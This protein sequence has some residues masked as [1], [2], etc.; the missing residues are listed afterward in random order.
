MTLHQVT[1]RSEGNKDTAEFSQKLSGLA[2]TISLCDHMGA[3][4]THWIWGAARSFRWHLSFPNYPILKSCSVLPLLGRMSFSEINGVLRGFAKQFRGFPMSN[5]HLFFEFSN[6]REVTFHRTRQYNVQH[7]VQPNLISSIS[8]APS[9][10]NKS[11]EGPW[12][13]KLYS[14][15]IKVCRQVKSKRSGSGHRQ[16][17]SESRLHHLVDEKPQASASSSVPQLSPRT[18]LRLNSSLKMLCNCLKC[19]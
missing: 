17:E 1:R 10:K 8:H 13:E 19:Y 12:P 2:S 4:S 16:R 9:L 6:C 3:V 18:L 5:S 14:W 7:T 11:Q 15:E